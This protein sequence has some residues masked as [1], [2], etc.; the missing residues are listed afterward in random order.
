M[1]QDCLS[2]CITCNWSRTSAEREDTRGGTK[3]LDRIQA[4]WVERAGRHGLLRPVRCMSACTRPCT[5]ALSGPGKF[6]L[7]F[8]DLDPERAAPGVMTT[9]EA[10]QSRAD[11]FLRR[12]E[13]HAAL[14]EGILARIP[15]PEWFKLD[16]NVP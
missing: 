16:G 10:F 7:L 1:T 12:E 15:P 6:T 9:F 8:G 2:V 3:L 5:V 14:Q 13:R 4:L 11:G